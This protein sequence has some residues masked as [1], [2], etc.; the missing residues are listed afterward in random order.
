MVLPVVER[1]L[2]VAARRRLTYRTRLIAAVAMVVGLVIA[3]FSFS[4]RNLTASQHG[5]NLF[6]IFAWVAFGFAALAGMIGTADCVSSEKREGT[7]G[8]LFLTDLKGYDI[9]L[10][11]LAANSMGVIYGLIASVPILS[12]PL[13][14]GGVTAMQVLETAALLLTVLALSCSIGIFASTYSTNERKAIV[15]AV[16]AMVMIVF[17]PIFIAVLLNEHRG[18]PTFELLVANFS[19]LFSLVIV[20]STSLMR[21]GLPWVFFHYHVLITLAWT[22]LLIF[23][24]LR[25]AAR[26]APLAWQQSE[27]TARPRERLFVWRIKIGLWKPPRALLD[28]NPYQWLALRGESSPKTVMG[29]VLCMFAIWGIGF[30]QY[31]RFMLDADVLT[32]TVV[33]VNTFLKIWVIG[34]ASRRFVEDRQNNALELILSTPLQAREIVKGQWGALVKL[35]AV[36]V[37]ATM[38]WEIFLLN[39]VYVRHQQ[40]DSIGMGTAFC[41]P[42]D[43]L[44]LGWFGM[45]LATKLKG[46][47]RVMVTGMIVVIGIPALVDLISSQLCEALFQGTGNQFKTLQWATISLASAVFDLALVAWSVGKLTRDFATTATATRATST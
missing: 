41:L 16:L 30:L 24:F 46:R 9:I 40:Q 33:I 34:E 23:L 3:E 36:P 19:P 32:P 14:M 27:T 6:Q 7:L 28:L 31:G 39:N 21:S 13:L 42:L 29:F 45:W 35:F 47:I 22:W 5:Q 12:L 43:C 18:V 1:E 38:V 4:N 2:R 17:L 20:L 10:G 26:K 25:F 37:L 8:L 44:A 15:F 11:K